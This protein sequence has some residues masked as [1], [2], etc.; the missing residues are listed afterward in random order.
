LSLCCSR[1]HRGIRATS[2][3]S[4]LSRPQIGCDGRTAPPL[5]LS[6]SGVVSPA[7][8][9]V[10]CPVLSDCLVTVQC[11]G[12]RSHVVMRLV[13][14]GGGERS[15]GAVADRSTCG[16][17]GIATANRTCRVFGRGREGSPCGRRSGPGGVRTC[18]R[19][20]GLV[21]CRGLGVS[22]RDGV[23]DGVGTVEVGVSA[24]LYHQASTTLLFRASFIRR[25]A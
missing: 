21:A 11:F 1:R 7:L 3:T 4:A 22:P 24:D 5:A 16:L 14:V 13:G 6:I 23:V 12:E 17:S 2:A 10:F 8:A 25:S 18:K 15:G 19:F 9:S 20:G